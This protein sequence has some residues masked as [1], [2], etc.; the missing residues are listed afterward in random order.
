MVLN[1][2]LRRPLH[3]QGQNA[4]ATSNKPAISPMCVDLPGADALT[5]KRGADGLVA[6]ECLVDAVAF[7]TFGL[8][9]GVLQP[10]IKSPLP[11]GQHAGPLKVL[12]L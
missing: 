9:V 4:S 3:H 5:L 8:V 7:D 6:D 11:A 10:T 2:P 12:L 1:K